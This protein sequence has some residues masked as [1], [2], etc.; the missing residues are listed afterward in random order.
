MCPRSNALGTS[1]MICILSVPHFAAI[2]L[3]VHATATR[4][5]KSVSV[6]FLMACLD[7]KHVH[8]GTERLQASQRR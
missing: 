4:L 5:G 8:A 6:I 2:S 7:G 3:P 1:D